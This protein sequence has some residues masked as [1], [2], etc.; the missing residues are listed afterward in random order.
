MPKDN[1]PLPSLP[2]PP[3]R[4]GLVPRFLS[5]LFATGAPAPRGAIFGTHEELFRIRGEIAALRA[6]LEAVRAEVGRRDI[7][8][9]EELQRGG[10]RR[11]VEALIRDRTHTVPLPDGSILCRVLGR[12]KM[13]VDAADAGIA[14]HLLLDGYWQ[15]WV[16]EFISRNVARGEIAYDVGAIY[17]YYTLLF[18]DLVG[19]D[20]RVV[21][22][23]ANPWLHGLLGRNIWLN[24]LGAVAT[25][26]RLAAAEGAQD[27]LTLP[28]LLTGPADGPFAQGFSGAPG[29]R[30]YTAPAVA[31]QDFEPG[32]IDVLRI[33]V[34]AQAARVVAGLAGLMDRSRN[35][36]ILLDYDAGRCADPAAL[37][38]T[39]AARYPLRFVD[40]DSRAKPTTIQDLLEH[41]RVATLY[42]SHMEP[43]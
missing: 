19:P 31:L 20:G 5:W 23:E 38:A 22:L 15:Y 42:L 13:F 32:A 18:A 40:G 3:R 17:G 27:A 25:A 14:P 33:G 28:A 34:P 39:L 21:A 37:L 26:H 16:T 36:R 41:R 30:L 10:N 8:T 6:A 1:P 9:L 7:A 29:R 12:F 43:A 2:A 35:L 4:A 24:G 11:E